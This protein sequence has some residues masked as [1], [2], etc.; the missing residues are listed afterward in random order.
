MHKYESFI[1]LG[2]F[3]TR[4]DETELAELFLRAE[5]ENPWF[6]KQQIEYCFQALAQMLRKDEIE[7][8]SN[9]Y[10]DF[11]EPETPLRIGIVAA[12]NIPLAVFH[13]M[14]CVL[15]SG[16]IFVCKLSSKDKVL[17]PFLAQKLIEL[18]PYLEKRIVFEKNELKKMDAYIATG[19]DNSSRYFEYYFSKFP[20]IIRKNRNSVALLTGD[21]TDE[22]LVLLAD[23]IFL[24]FGLGCRNVCKIFLPKGFDLFRIFRASH[25]YLHYVHHNKFANNFHYHRSIYMMNQIDFF[26]NEFFILKADNSYSS[27]ISV[28]YYEYYENIENIAKRLQN[29]MQLLQCVVSNYPLENAIPFGKAQMPHIMEYADQIDTMNF[30]IQLTK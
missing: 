9:Q 13:D 23:D 26:E 24:Y 4:S 16:H 12:G 7:K 11:I 21:E 20:C 6:T 14:L 25:K 22:E 1:Q 27:P 19:S 15:L 29:D 17:L 18:N 5:N 30:L 3:L 28:L 10:H 2:E 8:W